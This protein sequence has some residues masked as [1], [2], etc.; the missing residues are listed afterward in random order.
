MRLVL[1]VL[2][3]V[4]FAQPALAASYENYTIAVLQGLDKPNARVQRFEVPVGRTTAFG[5]LDV[6]VRAC[7]KTPA[8]EKT[9]EVAA[10]MEIDDTRE[11]QTPEKHKAELFKGWM[12][13]SS[14][15]LSAME[16]PVYDVWLLDCKNA[17]AKPSSEAPSVDASPKKATPESPKRKSP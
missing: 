11:K 16:H 6:T 12:F 13:A 15:A 9:P 7:R 17:D 5:P 8:E 10:Y 1:G 14:P 3:F 4:V 2:S